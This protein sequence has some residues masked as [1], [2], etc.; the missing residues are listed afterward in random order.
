MAMG[1]P[2]DRLNTGRILLFGSNLLLRDLFAQV[3]EMDPGAFDRAFRGVAGLVLL[4]LEE[5]ASSS[6][7]MVEMSGLLKELTTSRTSKKVLVREESRHPITKNVNA[8]SLVKME[9]QKNI[10]SNIVVDMNVIELSESNAIEPKEEVDMKKV[11]YIAN[12]EPIRSVGGD[13]GR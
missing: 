3:L 2:I 6:K 9:K 11:G 8:I 7:R 10:K 13:N 5:V 1:Y 4:S 12:N